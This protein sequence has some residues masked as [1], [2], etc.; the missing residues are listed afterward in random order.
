MSDTAPA[1]A[2]LRGVWFRSLLLDAAGVRDTTTS[3]TWVQ[4]PTRYADLR[5]P[6][7]RSQPRGITGLADLSASQLLDLT[8][9][10]AFAGRLRR[11]DDAYHWDRSFDFAPVALPD[12]GRLHRQGP[13]LIEE[14][15]HTP[16]VEHWHPAPESGPPH[17]AVDLTDAEDGRAGLLVRTGSW[18]CYVRDRAVPVPAGAPLAD[19]VRGAADLSQARLL[20]DLEVS[21][22]RI[23]TGRWTVRRSTLPHRVGADLAPRLIL[24]ERLS[25][26]DTGPGGTPRT[27][28]FTVTTGEGA[29]FALTAHAP[30]GVHS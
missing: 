21:L 29:L 15:L 12:S 26:A 19:L 17:A 30:K 10:E 20:V 16:Y 3:V 23:A 4:G 13:A 7:D 14:G 1:L 18:F 5:Q 22:G 9:Q 28:V 8:A 25:V 11:L 27:R 6:A 24:S 2:D